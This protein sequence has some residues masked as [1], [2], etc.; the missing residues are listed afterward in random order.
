MGLTHAHAPVH[1]HTP[2]PA[3]DGAGLPEFSATFPLK[4]H[5]DSYT[6]L[7]VDARGL[8]GVSVQ[9]R[10]RGEIRALSFI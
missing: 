4:Y 5:C 1:T 6:L 7:N 9:F 8:E 3:G 2:A 10:D